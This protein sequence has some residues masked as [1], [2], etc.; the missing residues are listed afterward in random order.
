MVVLAVGGGGGQFGYCGGGGSG[1]VAYN[2]SLPQKEYIR[3]L[4]HAGSNG[5]DSYVI[6][7]SNGED[8]V[9]GA[10]GEDGG[11]CYGEYNGGAGMVSLLPIDLI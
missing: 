9:R 4:A 10:R 1:Y 3:L 2:M 7:M 8:V 11:E 6:D 5:E